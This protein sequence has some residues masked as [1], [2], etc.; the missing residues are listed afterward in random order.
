MAEKRVKQAVKAVHRKS[1]GDKISA[2]QRR[3]TRG[4]PAEKRVAAARAKLIFARKR[5]R[6]NPTL[7]NTRALD[8]ARK[9]FLKVKKEG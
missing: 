1:A 6:Q 5:K 7:A 2:S 8:T 3:M 4:T 9:N